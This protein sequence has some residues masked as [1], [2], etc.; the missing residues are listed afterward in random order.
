MRGGPVRYE[1]PGG[2]DALPSVVVL[3]GGHGLSANLTALRRV[4]DRLTAVVTVADDGGSSGRLRDELDC[5]PPGD[6]R[7]AL[8]ALCGDHGAGRRWAEVLQYRFDSEGTLA[9]HPIGNLLIA[10]IWQQVGDPVAGLE[11]VAEL[12]GAR[13]RVLP[14]AGTPLEIEAEIVGHDPG[15][16]E[17][18][19]PVRG[20]VAVASTPGWIQSITLLPQ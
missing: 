20:Q 19:V 13:G 4:T 17:D 8:A 6:L 16:P 5:L 2:F 1:T 3:G 18:I 9:G 7:M 12:I 14:M 10:G 15:R 11:L